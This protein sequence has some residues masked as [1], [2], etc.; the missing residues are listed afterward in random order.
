M[1]QRGDLFW[2]AAAAFTLTVCALFP[3][4]T[5]YEYSGSEEEEEENDSGEPRYVEEGW[6]CGLPPSGP[7]L[8]EM[9]SPFDLLLCLKECTRS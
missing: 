8:L 6:D 2:A 3:D 4:E 9:H 5:E 7:D 1:K